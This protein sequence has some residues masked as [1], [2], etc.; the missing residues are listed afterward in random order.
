MIM[1]K[2]KPLVFIPTYN[3]KGNIVRL[4][5]HLKRLDVDLDLLFIDDCSPDGSGKI[6]DNLA[7]EDSNLNVIH[8]S[9]KLGI[10]SAHKDGIAWAYSQG[11]KLLITMDS[12]YA[13][14]PDKI[15]GFIKLSKEN[16]LVVGSRYL[17]TNSM[18]DLSILRRVL[19]YTA[20]FM[21]QFFLRMPYDSTNAFR[22]YRLDEIDSTLFRKISSNSYSFFFESLYIMHSQN[23]SIIEIPIKIGGRSTGHSKMSFFD[24]LI[25]IKILVIVTFKKYFKGL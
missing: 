20:H 14:S 23:I 2:D 19:S 8:R 17:E 6:L 21:T 11:Y 15:E 13:H 5:D 3:E 18:S 7:L 16:N 4:Y 25:S 10:G 9:G 24:A 22:L 12:D 1:T